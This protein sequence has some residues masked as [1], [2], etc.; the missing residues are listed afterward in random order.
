M[1]MQQDPISGDAYVRSVVNAAPFDLLR[2]ATFYFSRFQV[3]GGGAD[4]SGNIMVSDIIVGVDGAAV[5]GRSLQELKDLFLGTPWSKVELSFMRAK[6]P[7]VMELV[8]VPLTR[9]PKC[10]LDAVQ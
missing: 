7:S 1:V 3:P 6:S 8:Q 4:R 9:V 2:I 10:Y 5:R